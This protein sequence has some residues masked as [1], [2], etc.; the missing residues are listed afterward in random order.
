MNA[1]ARRILVRLAIVV[2]WTSALY[3]IYQATNRY[4][5]FTPVLLPLTPL[6]AAIPFWSWTVVPYFAL[7]GGMYLP[8]LIRDDLLFKRALVALTIGVLINYSIFALWPTT[9]IRPPLPEGGAFYDGWYRWLMTIDTPA[10]CFPSGHITAPVIGC[11]ALAQEHP[12]WR[13][14]IRLVMVPFVL[15]ILTTKQHYVWDL[16]GG[17]TTAVIGIVAANRLYGVRRAARGVE[18]DRTR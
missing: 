18:D 8:A 3:T 16:F 10:N 6:D 14:A 1:D 12:R 9:I 7:I 17:L 11:W 4:H 15:T 2:G 13:W 5:L